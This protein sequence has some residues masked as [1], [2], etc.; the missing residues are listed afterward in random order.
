MIAEGAGIFAVGFFQGAPL[1]VPKRLLVQREAIAAEQAGLRVTRKKQR[2]S[3]SRS[4]RRLTGLAAQRL[5]EVPIGLQS[6]PQ[7]RRGLEASREPKCRIGGN[8]A[9]PQDDLIQS[10]ER[11]AQALGGFELRPGD[12]WSDAK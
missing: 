3:A 7:L 6:H 12:S 8:A 9:L 11:D 1:K 4:S 5:M 10:V 2:S